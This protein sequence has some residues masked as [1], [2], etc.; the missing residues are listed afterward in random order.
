MP[1]SNNVERNS[2]LTPFS[3]VS[4]ARRATEA[5]WPKA[6]VVIGNPPF[7]GNRKMIRELGEDYTFTL[8]RVYEGR[9]PG[10]ADLV[11][12]WFE[13][14]RTAIETNGLGAA[15]LVATNSIRGGANRKVLDA[16]S[17]DLHGTQSL[18]DVQKLQANSDTSF[19]GAQKNG[20]FDIPREVAVQWLR[21]PNPHGKSNA[22][23]V[24]PWANGL[25]VTR[26][27]QD[28]WVVDFGCDMSLNEAALFEVPFAHVNQVVKPTRT[29]VRRDR[30]RTHWWL[31]G[32]AR[33]P[34]PTTRPSASCTAVSTNYGF[35][36]W[37][38]RL[39]IGRAT[40]PPPVSKL[41]LSPPA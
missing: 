8:R 7:L 20:P 9:V 15:G 38:H 19:I 29:D 10:G 21:Q 25:D 31:Y 2:A 3:A 28:R 33:S 16:I 17:S 40:P 1:E 26:R 14:A 5:A 41:S 13:K 32:D 35:C 39:K 22:L 24:R 12:Y 37:V 11:C 6:S 30:H 27:P 4:E 18:S 34:A 23:V 36:A